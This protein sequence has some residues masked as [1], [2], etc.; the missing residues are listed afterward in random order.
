[1][2]RQFTTVCMGICMLFVAVVPASAYQYVGGNQNCQQCHTDYTSGSD[3]HNAHAKIAKDDCGKCH[4]EQQKV[5]ASTCK[6]CHAKLPCK[7]VTEHNDRGTESCMACHASCQTEEPGCPASACLGQNDPRIKT[8]Q[9][10]RDN[11]L[12]KSASGRVLISAYYEAGI[13]VQKYLEAHPGLKASAAEVLS[14]IA[15]IVEPF[16]SEGG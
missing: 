8:L 6:Q 9:A 14:W 10:F 13:A 4:D 11:V 5:P 15:E 7:W 3:W 2:G 16:S 1:M 12:A